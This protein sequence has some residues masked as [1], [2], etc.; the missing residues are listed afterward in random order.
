M[1]DGARGGK[2]IHA[3]KVYREVTGVGLAEAK[4]AVDAMAREMS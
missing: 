2:V 1:F 3:I 4:A